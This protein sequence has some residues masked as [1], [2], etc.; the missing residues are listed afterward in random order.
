MSTQTPA[1][2]ARDVAEAVIAEMEAV[3]EAPKEVPKEEPVKD[4]AKEPEVKPEAKVETP[5]PKA[6]RPER[7]SAFVPV[8]KANQWRHEANDAKAKVADLE[9][10]LAEAKTPQQQTDELD[11]VAKE[12][13]GTDASPE[14]VKRILE[15]TKK[16]HAPQQSE[17]VKSLLGLKQKLEADAEESAFQKDVSSVT[18]RFPELKGHE[19]DLREM[20][21]AEGNEKIPLE[22]L[23]YKLRDDLN[24][25]PAPSSAE[26]KASK[27][28][29][30]AEPDFANMTEKDVADLSDSDLDRFIAFQKK[31]LHKRTGMRI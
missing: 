4:A 24:L 11:A 8:A 27:P 12:I 1:E 14:V 10:Q 28:T 16:F 26:G 17:E 30:A 31:G 7:K 2:S 21:Y 15:A 20:A 18:T 9:R 6:E 5:E 3:Q 19:T 23:A 13:A 25:S 29:Q 22:L